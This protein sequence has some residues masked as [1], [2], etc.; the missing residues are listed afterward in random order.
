M[1]AGFD[2]GMKD[3]YLGDNGGPLI[4]TEETHNMLI[5]LFS[6]GEECARPGLPGVYTR[7]GSYLEWIKHI[8]EEEEDCVC[9][10][11]MA[12]QDKQK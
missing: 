5:G 9:D 10:I 3:A 7:V 11:G 4:K 12:K 8:L 2:E 6:L 1:C